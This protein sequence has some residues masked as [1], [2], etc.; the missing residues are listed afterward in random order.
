MGGLVHWGCSNSKDV[1]SL[2]VS[3]FKVLGG[4]KGE[5]WNSGRME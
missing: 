5:G 2:G 1:E 3:R 4:T